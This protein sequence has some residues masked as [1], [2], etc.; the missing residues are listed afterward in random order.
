MRDPAGRDGTGGKGAGL[1]ELYR[2]TRIDTSD[3]PSE[4]RFEAWRAAAYSIVTLEAPGQD[5]AL[6]EGTKRLVRGASGTFS[7]YEGSAHRTVFSRAASRA[8]AMDSVVLSFMTEGTLGLESPCGASLSP[9]AGC[10][11]VYDTV[12]PMRY[13]WGTGKEICVLLPR[14]PALA[15]MGGDLPGLLVPLDPWPLGAFVRQQMLVLDRFADTMTP[16]EMAVALDALSDLAFLLLR[17]IG[18]ERHGRA[19]DDADGTDRLHEAARHYIRAH[20]HV[21]GLSPE[22]IA[23]ALGCSRAN[24]YRAF[25]RNGATIMETVREIRLSAARRLVAGEG[26]RSIAS[27]AH[28]CGFADASAFGRLFRA[29]FGVTPRDWRARFR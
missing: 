20:Y 6:I 22:M 9:P 16:E 11:A 15:A 21:I 1:P 27:I 4:T 13:H 23:H 3:F 2:M 19:R 24:L 28:G 14:G 12:R 26:E 29:R 8:G 5:D 17:K 18:I 10:L 7:T 25:A